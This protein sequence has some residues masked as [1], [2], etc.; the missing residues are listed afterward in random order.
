[1]TEQLPTTLYEFPHSH[2]CEIAR[3]G[4]SY[5]GIDYRSI[6]L[7]PGWHALRMKAL[8]RDTSLPVL[9]IDGQAIQGSAEI[10][11]FL[12][13]RQ[14]DPPLGVPGAEGQVRS[15]ELEAAQEIGEPIRQL[16]YFHLLDDPGLVRHFFM[17]RSPL[18][19]RLA[20]GILYPHI[21]RRI[22]ERYDCTEA[23]AKQAR[24]RLTAAIAAFD[25]RL[26]R[27]TYFFDQ[28]FTR[29]DLTFAALT[30]FMVMPTEYPVPW[31]A[32]L[33]A[34][35]LIAWFRGFADTASYRHVVRVYADHR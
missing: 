18:L 25:Q 33:N 22:A 35:P 23:G 29:A 1:M 10:L 9:L 2:F 19:Q 34:H 14:G 27:Q 28:R 30:A 31:P 3:W 32:K 11:D 5:K 13:E 20:F 12:E 24:S 8:V 6:P 15:F 16:C 21:R 4:L 26:D 7:L 17:H